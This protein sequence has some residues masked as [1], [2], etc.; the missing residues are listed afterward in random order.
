MKNRTT[1]YMDKNLIKEAKQFAIEKE[2]TFSKLVEDAVSNC[3]DCDK[4]DVD[5]TG[6]YPMGGFKNNESIY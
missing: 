5:I 6:H 4:H 3:I 1:I 2:V